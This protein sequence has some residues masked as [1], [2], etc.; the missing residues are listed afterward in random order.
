MFLLTA[1]TLWPKIPK[2]SSGV[3]N[4]ILNQNFPIPYFYFK[5][6][7][8]HSLNIYA[9]TL[10]AEISK[11]LDVFRQSSW[12][13]N[14]KFRSSYLHLNLIIYYNF[15]SY[16]YEFSQS[17]FHSSMIVLLQCLL[18]FFTTTS[19]GVPLKKWP[20]FLKPAKSVNNSNPILSRAV[21]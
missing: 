5:L 18:P 6:L 16:D 2:T 7:L 14:L 12:R 9:V 13:R 11:F 4:K 21:R 3:I 15:Q 19:G 1:V 10:F 20:D 8:Q 17:S